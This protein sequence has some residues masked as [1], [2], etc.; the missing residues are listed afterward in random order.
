[1]RFKCGLTEEELYQREKDKFEKMCQWYRENINVWK[2]KFA[3]LPVE[4]EPGTC[5]WLEPYEVKVKFNEEHRYL[6]STH[7][8]L[9]AHCFT[10]MTT[11]RLKQWKV[12]VGNSFVVEKR[13]G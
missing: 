11:K 5:V 2:R 12:D 6:K 8:R 4:I 10:H 3:W 1:M 13:L 7:T 9:N